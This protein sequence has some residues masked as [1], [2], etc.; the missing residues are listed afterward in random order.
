MKFLVIIFSIFSLGTAAR[1]IGSFF[2]V[3][4]FHLDSNYSEHGD[5]QLWCHAFP[6]GTEGPEI[7]KFGNYTCDAPLALIKAT[8][9]GMR[10]ILPNPDFIIWTGDSLPHVSNSVL[11]MNGN[12]RVG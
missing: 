2:H 11:N 12:N 6:N 8:T 4:D 10:Q 7:G 9:Q 3:T 1:N 5:L